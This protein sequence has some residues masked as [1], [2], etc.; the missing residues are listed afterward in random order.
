M[1]F[2]TYFCF[3]IIIVEQKTARLISYC[4]PDIIADDICQDQ[5]AYDYAK[6][7]M[8]LNKVAHYVELNYYPDKELLVCIS[9]INYSML[10]MT[11][12]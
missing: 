8:P 11:H 2:K 12:I 6:L 7:G 3:A 4:F 5:R 1:F 10:G 9:H